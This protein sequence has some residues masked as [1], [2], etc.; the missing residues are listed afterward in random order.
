MEKEVL[1]LRDQLWKVSRKGQEGNME[2]SGKDW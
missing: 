2:P 1:E